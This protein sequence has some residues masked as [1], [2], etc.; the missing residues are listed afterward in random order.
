MIAAIA[1]CPLA[2]RFSGLTPG[3]AI[4]VAFAVTLAFIAPSLTLGLALRRRGSSL[5]AAAALIAATA[6]LLARAKLDANAPLGE[7]ML[8]E[9]LVAGLV[10]LVVGALVALVFP[11]RRSACSLPPSDPFAETP[12]DPQS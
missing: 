12:F 10:G 9:A 8:K 4:T 3:A 5:V 11:A 7:A 1:L 2:S 6:T